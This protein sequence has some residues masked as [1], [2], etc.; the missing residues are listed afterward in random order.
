MVFMSISDEDTYSTVF[1]SLKHPIRRKILRTLFEGPQTFS[2]LQ[3]QIGIESSHLTYHLEELGSLLLKTENGAYQLSSLGEAAVSTMKQVEEP[4]R[5]LKHLLPP[6]AK[7]ESALKW[8]TLFLVCSLVTSLAFNGIFLLKNTEL[9]TAYNGLEKA[10]NGLDQAYI[11]LNTTY[12]G[13]NQIYGELNR[14]SNELEGAYANLS[15]SYQSVLSNSQSNTVRNIETGME[16]STIQQAI[17]AAESGN[18]ILVGSG[19]YYEHLVVNKSLTLLGVNK[20]DTIID[21]LSTN[22]AEGSIGITITTDNVVVGGLTVK[23]CSTG[24]YLDNSNGSVVTGNIVTLSGSFGIFLYQCYNA[25]ISGNIVSSTIGSQIGLIFGDGIRLDSSMNNTISDNFIIESPWDAINLDSSSNNWILRNVIE[26]I[27]HIVSAYSSNNNTFFHN[28]FINSSGLFLASSNNS[29]NVGGQG[30]YWSDYRGLD[31]DSDGVGDTDLPWHGVDDYP[32][33]NP[34]NPILVFWANEIFPLS[35]GSNST[36]SAFAFDQA[37]KEIT[38]NVI[39]PANT[40]GFLTISIPS[41]LL[42]G[43]WA[44]L[45]DGNAV[46]EATITK[47]ETFTTINLSYDYISHSIQI[48]GAN[49]IPEYSTSVMLVPMLLVILAAIAIKRYLRF[50]GPSV[51]MCHNLTAENGRAPR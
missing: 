16:F 23:N 24:V 43:P 41:S 48:I 4:S 13:L 42:A 3:K 47:N 22:I 44:I 32:L 29:W 37:Y 33:I 14:T 27:S 2:D 18:I 30:N 15:Q 46:N 50:R 17:N 12:G 7:R 6:R 26:N 28:N 35:I 10:Y 20:E 34:V 1:S 9:D 8:L 21:G 40:T 49:V 36:V 39:G 25:I 5:N 11:D 31:N 51:T 38:F 45:L 19:V